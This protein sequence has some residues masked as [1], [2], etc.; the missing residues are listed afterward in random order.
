MF[1]LFLLLYFLH[2]SGHFFHFVI[3]EVDASLLTIIGFPAFAVDDAEVKICTQELIRKKLNVS[4]S[5]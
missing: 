5:F 4:F 2:L 3:Q 1:C